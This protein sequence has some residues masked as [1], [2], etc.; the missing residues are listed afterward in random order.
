MESL[1]VTIVRDNGYESFVIEDVETFLEKLRANSRIDDKYKRMNADELRQW[2]ED[3]LTLHQ[4]AKLRGINDLPTGSVDN[5]RS[6][7]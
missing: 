5:E 6:K 3:D 2:V 7:L 1:R 4:F